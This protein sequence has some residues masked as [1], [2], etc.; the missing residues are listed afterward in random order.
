MARSKDGDKQSFLPNRRRKPDSRSFSED[1]LESRLVKKLSPLL[2]IALAG[3]AHP[4]T[5][6]PL[7]EK[8]EYMNGIALSSATTPACVFQAGYQYSNPNELLVKVRVLNKGK[9]PFDIDASSFVMKGPLETIPGSPMT[10]ADP[11]KYIQGLKSSAD[12]QDSRAQMETY[13]GVEELGVLK[14]N[15]GD[16]QIEAARDAYKRKTK[17]AENSRE[18]AAKLRERIAVIEPTVLKKNTV[19]PGEVVE[20]ALIFPSK[21]GDTGVVTIETTNTACPASISF[22]LKK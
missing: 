21:F 8:P 7:G 14:G 19:K 13:Q 11:A 20:G 4:Y 17:E 18:T 10:P 2:L 5:L 1:A 9:T 3:C 6:D 22:M 15:S 12:L 16:Q